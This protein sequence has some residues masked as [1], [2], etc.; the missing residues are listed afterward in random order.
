MYVSF[1]L[2]SHHKCWLLYISILNLA[3]ALH[4]DLC[5]TKLNELK[6]QINLK[7]KIAFRTILTKLL[8]LH[9]S[10]ISMK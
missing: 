6:F 10:D 9:K 1:I 4:Q 7:S 3:N 5:I 8:S 2:Q